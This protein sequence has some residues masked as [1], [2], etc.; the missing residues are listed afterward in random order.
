MRKEGITM[1]TS[2]SHESLTAADAG[3]IARTLEKIDD[4]AICADGPV[5]PT[6]REATP[7]ELRRIYR[8]AKR[9]QK[10]Y[11]R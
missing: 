2:R 5:T 6:L 9:I 1:A 3:L 11:A 7:E 10:R 8:A 4:R